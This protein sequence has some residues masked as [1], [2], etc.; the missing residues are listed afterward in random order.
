MFAHLSAVVTSATSALLRG[1]LDHH[2]DL[3]GPDNE[4]ALYSASGSLVTMFEWRGTRVM[5]DEAG[6]THAAVGLREKTAGWLGAPGHSLQVVF[7]RDPSAAGTEADAALAGARRQIAAQSL[8]LNDVLNARRDTLAATGAS[9]RIYLS[10]YTHPTAI[11]RAE[12]KDMMRETKLSMAGLPPVHDAQIPTVVAEQLRQAHAAICAGLAEDLAF[13]GQE[14]RRLTASEAAQRISMSILP[15]GESEGFTP[16]LAGLPTND[17]QTRVHAQLMPE[18][19]AA[20]G[21][22]DYSY[23]GTERL[24]WQLLRDHAVIGDYGTVRIGSTVF[25]PFDL[26]LLP[27]SLVPFGQLVDAVLGSD[28]PIRWRMSFLI[29]SG[30]WAGTVWKRSFSSFFAFV[31]RTHNSRI[32]DAFSALEDIDGSEE[33]IVRLRVCAA[34]WDDAG[35]ED[36]LRRAAARLRQAVERW[37]NARCETLAGDPIACLFGSLPGAGSAPTAPSATAPLTDALALLPLDRPSSPWSTGS[38]PMTSAD[39][40]IWPYAPGSPL[41]DSWADLLSGAPGS[42]KSVLINSMNA[43]TILAPAGRD[44]PPPVIGIIDIGASSAGLVSMIREALPVEE[45]AHAICARLRNSSDYAINVFDTLPGARRPTALGRTFLVNFIRLLLDAS[46]AGAELAG[47]IGAAID[48]AYETAADDRNPKRWHE[49]TDPG[50]D[51]A[52]FDCGWIP[53]D[54]STWW[55]SADFLADHG[56]WDLAERAQ[57]HAVPL[58]SD[59]AAAAAAARVADNYK[60]MRLSTG[61]PALDGLRRILAEAAADW[62]LLSRPTVFSFG[63]ARLRAVDLQDVTDRSSEATAVRR[64]ALMYMLARH[65]CTEGFYLVPEDVMALKLRP[66]QHDRM[67]QRAKMAR[68]TRKRLSIDEFH[69]AGGLPGIVD[70]VATDIREGRKH[71]VQIALASQLLADFDPRLTEMATGVWICQ[72]GEHDIRRATDMLNL[73]SAGIYALRHRLTG[74]RAGGSPVFAALTVKGGDVRQLLT[75]TLGPEEIW[76]W[77]TTAEDVA[78]RDELTRLLGP[79][80]ARAALAAAYPGGSARRAV[81]RRTEAASLRGEAGGTIEAMADE[82]AANWQR[83]AA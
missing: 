48:Q 8:D 7:I 18:S 6:M 39:G 20:L 54:S 43:A 74:P 47:L 59:L 57:R 3:E 78:L 65:V 28:D 46:T 11:P 61:E 63:E 76:A 62:S 33:T 66:S 50:V 69:R 52:L 82:I 23:L 13:A 19:R 22:K 10:V 42:G 31:N 21:G 49:G 9:E 12:R 29:E 30:G 55:E 64:S 1:P 24:S 37:G 17:G 80:E 45:R 38:L 75:H 16:R 27:E 35:A 51:A 56:Y 67:M 71:G 34:V 36:R 70:Q 2:I 81:A 83:Q 26:A 41:Q 53:D 15:G 4:Y 14:V 60:D 58:I 79:N 72:A 25:C 68:R 5:L 73:D 40:R 32:R 44:D 77:S